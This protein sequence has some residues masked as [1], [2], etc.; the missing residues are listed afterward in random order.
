[1]AVVIPGVGRVRG[2]DDLSGKSDNDLK[3]IVSSLNNV[4]KKNG[5]LTSTQATIL[6]NAKNMQTLR[7][8]ARKA[9]PG[10]FRG[11]VSLTPQQLTRLASNKKP[12]AQ[13]TIAKLVNQANSA[14]NKARSRKG[15]VTKRVNAAKKK[16][17]GNP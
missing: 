11:L 9:N 15:Q 12:Y 17:T 1:M 2:D 14:S 16:A 8:N 7:A 5:R 10:V 3:K 13:Q 6:Q 4:N